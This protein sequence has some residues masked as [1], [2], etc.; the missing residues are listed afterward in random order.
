VPTGRRS[1]TII[2]VMD[3]SDYLHLD[4]MLGAQHPLSTDH[5]ATQTPS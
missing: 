3:Y 2:G 4:E 1:A 5:I